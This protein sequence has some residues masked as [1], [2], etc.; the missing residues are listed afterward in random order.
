[1]GH[2]RRHSRAPESAALNVEIR[3]FAR[4]PLGRILGPILEVFE[5]HGYGVQHISLQF[6]QAV[7]ASA[8]GRAELVAIA[9]QRSSETCELLTAEGR[10]EISWN[11]GPHAWLQGVWGEIEASSAELK[12][13][14]GL[15]LGLA[16]LGGGVYGYADAKR[17][18]DQDSRE[19]GGLL[20]RQESLVGIYWLN[21][22]GP[23]IALQLGGLGEP[24]PAFPLLV[25]SREGGL[26]FASSAE[27]GGVDE[28]VARSVAERWPVFA[29]LSRG[30]RFPKRLELDLSEVRSLSGPGPEEG[31]TAALLGDV[32]A[33]LERV[34]E[35]AARF[36]QWCEQEGIAC[37]TEADLQQVFGD[38]A[39]TIRSDRNLLLAAVAAYGEAVR[40]TTGGIWTRA[41]LF[42]R[43]EAVIGRPWQPWTR[44]RVVLEVLQFFEPPEL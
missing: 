38:R 8:E 17:K 36:A 30:A 13:L 33:F 7:A 24:R 10:F 4:R 21:Y 26:L 41:H 14:G 43:G 2:H 3:L 29:K 40:R 1:M 39:A 32:E 20:L 16:E 5:A 37:G 18:L 6:A 15:L 34:P 27:P 11:Y 22:L 35:H 9:A 25:R 23:E 12:K 44:R 28:A 19:V 42:G 31:T